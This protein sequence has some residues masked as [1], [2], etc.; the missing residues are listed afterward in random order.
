MRTKKIIVGAIMTFCISLTAFAQDEIWYFG[1]S[2]DGLDF[3]GG[4][5][6]VIQVPSGKGPSGFY[7]CN[8]SVSDGFG[9]LLFYTDGLNIYNK[10]HDVMP[11]GGGLS[12][13]NEPGQTTGSSSQGV[14]IVQDPGNSDRYYILYADCIHNNFADGYRYTVVD[15]TLDGSNGDV[16][17]GFKDLVIMSGVGQANQVGEFLNAVCVAGTT[18][19]LSHRVGSDEFLAHKI[20]ASGI[21]LTPVVS[22]VGPVIGQSNTGQM[23]GT[24]AFSHGGDKLALA[25]GGKGVYIFDFDASTGIVSNP[26]VVEEAVKFY[27]GTEWSPDDSKL[28]F[29]QYIGSPGLFQYDVAT[30]GI[31]QYAGGPIGSI[32]LAPDGKI[33]GAPGNPARTALSVVNSPDALGGAANYVQDQQGGFSGGWITLGLP[34][35]FVCIPSDTCDIDPV[36]D[37]CDTTSAFQL[38]ANPEGN[39]WGGGAYITAGGV[40]DPSLAGGG[41]H[42]V[43]NNGGCVGPD[44][45]Q[46]TVNVCCPDLDPNLGN[47]TTICDDASIILD[48]GL[49]FD[50][51][52]WYENGV[53]MVG[54]IGSTLI[55]D[56][57]TYVIEVEDINGCT[58]TD[59]IEVGNNQLPIVDLGPDTFYCA[60]HD[61]TVDAGAGFSIYAW[62]PSGGSG[63]TATFSSA[64]TYTVTVTDINGCQN[65]DDIIITEEALPTPTITGSS[66]VCEDSSVVLTANTGVG[67]SHIWTGGSILNT[68]TVTAGGT[69]K[70]YEMNPSGCVDSTEQTVSLESL[71]NVELGGP[72]TICYTQG[73]QLL[74]ASTGAVGESYLWSDNS[75]DPTL[76][77]TDSSLV[78]V[79]VTSANGCIA[80]DTAVV[81]TFSLPVVNL[82]SDTFFCSGLSIDLDAGA[83]FTSYVW[84]PSGSGQVNTV[85]SSATYDVIVTDANGCMGYDTVVVDE[86]ALP[87]VDLGSD[88]TICESDSITLDATHP[89]AAS[90]L[91]TPNNENTAT[92]K[93]GST[94]ETY[95]V[96]ITDVDGCE[97][98]TSRTI[99]Q[100]DLPVVDLGATDTI[101][102]DLTKTLDA[103]AGASQSYTWYLDGSVI[104]GETGQT[105]AADSGTYVVSV[106][107]ALGCETRDTVLIDNYLS[108]PEIALHNL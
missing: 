81:D 9:N 64:N 45:I 36:A 71:P 48:A 21:N 84:S 74:D 53:L 88:I 49:G 99:S 4:S 59:T 69:Y 20:D 103:G 97:F 107:T 61:V 23:R 29:S 24:M 33:Y 77:I 106:T 73:S 62:S 98:T 38:T 57:G 90:Y 93:V 39:L 92:I 86:N 12:G 2:K 42:W 105:I 75:T 80:Y 17:P 25:S 26:V 79:I 100:E 108:C 60:T 52:R 14:I 11:N 34:D 101:C 40:F 58:G 37:V 8:A 54:Q 56:S 102:D 18:W 68:L 63:Q 16:V 10:N 91:W 35:N 83:G 3:S 47:D 55:A 28:Y 50:K 94:P 67:S 104:A 30:T 1:A 13:P 43:T 41:T 78:S 85:S 87:E 82:G 27:Y 19:V 89:D 66:I 32:R 70:L 51:Y 31:H 15:M 65:S 22:P 6:S 95:G 76:N 7:E 46:I 96:T 72:Y 44:S 5:P